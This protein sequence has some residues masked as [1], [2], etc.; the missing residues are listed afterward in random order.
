MKKKYSW[1]KRTY[2]VRAEIVGAV[3]EALEEE[4]GS[5]TAENL[6]EASKPEDSPTHKL[7]E[8][9]DT[10]AANNYR[11][12]QARILINNLRIEIVKDDKSLKVPAYVNVV[13][14][15]DG[16]ARY[17]NAPRAFEAVETREIVLERAKNE[18]Q[19]FT[20]KYA[21]FIEFAKVIDAINEVI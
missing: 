21:T 2:S 10:K 4:F 17:Q 16:T 12:C 19:M 20:I 15:E 14:K 5:V 1:D 11:L 3:F 9:N 18:L 7:F 8:W 6:L 13:K